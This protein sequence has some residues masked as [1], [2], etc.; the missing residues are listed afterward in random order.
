MVNLI[1][2]NSVFKILKI[3][4]KEAYRAS[5]NKLIIFNVPLLLF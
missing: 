1:I 2:L 3:V 4:K 5:L